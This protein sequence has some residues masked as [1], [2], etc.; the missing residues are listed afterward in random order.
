MSTD[1]ERAGP[2][3]SAERI[4]Y[5]DILRGMALFGILA[6]NMRGFNAPLDLYGNI[7][8]LFHGRADLIAQGFIDIFI[9]GKFVTLFSFLFGLGFAVQMTRAAARGAKFMSFYPRRLAALALF[10]LIHGLLI[11]WG[12]ILLTYALSGTMLLFFRNRSQKT[13][14]WWAGSIFTLPILVITGVYIAGIFGHGPASHPGKPFDLST[15]QPIIAI[16]S[17]GSVAQ[18]LRENL[19]V[20]KHALPSAA[21]SIYALFL[22]LLGLWVYRS[23]IIERLGDY[24]PLLKRVCAVCLPL[25]IALNVL[26]VFLQSKPSVE[27]A[28]LIEYLATVLDL[29]AAHVLSAGYASGLAVLIQ[30]AAWKRWLTPFA[31]V[32]RMALTDYLMQS[33][34]CT[35]FYYNYTTGLFGRVGPAMGLIP[36]VVLYGAQVVFSNWWLARY[37]FGPMEWLWRGMTYGKLP[38]MR[39]EPVIA[40][41]ELPMA[42]GAASSD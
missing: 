32:G 36:T 24:K 34:V 19:V 9:Q 17:H 28:R 42:S 12:D 15:V 21:F 22:F 5:I 7:R 13:V 11:W 33:V 40:N 14:L 23:G 3:T 27:H 38:S 10:G 31:A 4:L 35:L 20:W 39:R 16:Y 18:I 1:V 26:V 2:I 41:A 8:P 25:G 6:A 30:S 37:R 29:P